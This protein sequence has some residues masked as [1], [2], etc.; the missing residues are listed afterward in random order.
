MTE[1]TGSP[2]DGYYGFSSSSALF[3]TLS[4]PL[5][6]HIYVDI[7]WPKVELAKREQRS[8]RPIVR[9]STTQSGLATDYCWTGLGQSVRT[10]YQVFDENM[11]GDQ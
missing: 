1:T 5:F 7:Q 9:S 2:L 8:F 4:G 3:E 11:P 10:F 6:D